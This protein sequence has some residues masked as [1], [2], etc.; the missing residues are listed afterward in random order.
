MG[1]STKAPHRPGFVAAALAALLWIGCPGSIP[2][3]PEPPGDDDDDVED[4]LDGFFG[5]G[6][7]AEIHIGLDDEAWASLLEAP[8]EYVVGSVTID[9]ADFPSVGV[10]LKGAAGSFVALDGD[11]PEGS[12]DGNG[13]PGKSAFII[14]FNRYVDGGQFHELEKLTLNNLAQDPSGFHE[15]LG[16]ALFRE[17]EVPAP[18]SGWATV[19]LNGEEKGLYVTLE[20][21]DN[22]EFLERW[23]GTDQ[24]NLYEGAYGVDLYPDHVDWFEQDNGDDESRDDLRTLTSALDAIEPDDDVVGELEALID[25]DEYLAFSATELYLG[26]W[27]G[28]AWSVNNYRFHIHPDT[29][30][31]T[32]LPWGIDQ[33][34]A[35]DL[36]E[37]AGVIQTFGPA[38]PWGGRVH[39]ICFLSEECRGRLSDA[40]EATIERVEQMDLEELAWDARE[41]VEADVLAEAEEYGDPEYAEAAMDGVFGFIDERG[42]VVEEWLPCLTGGSVDSDGDGFDGCTVDCDDGDPHVHPGAAEECDFRDDDCNGVIDDPEECPDCLDHEGVDGAT[43]SLCLE[44]LSWVEA[45]A[46]CQDRGQELASFHDES[47]WEQVTW[48]FVELGDHWETWSGLND[49]QTEGEFVWSDGSDLDL[50]LWGDGAPS[51]WGEDVDCVVNTLWGWWDFWCDEPMPFVCKTS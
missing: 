25:L 30:A 20:A 50:L 6:Q 35:D 39:Q 43:Y 42:G 14:D 47:T 4:P 29:G 19:S 5:T 45:E 37:H 13:A 17:G 24:G 1:G 49:L 21:E 31:T 32:F 3:D 51:E 12:G 8:R 46:F 18:R 28:Y 40:F 48:G 9:D 27:D 36:G 10:R 23:Y 2:G 15:Y 41:L 22:D 34:F 11:Y 7:I 26:H 33:L 38:W 16:Y 44:W